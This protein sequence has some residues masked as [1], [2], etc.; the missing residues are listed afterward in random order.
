MQLLKFQLSFSY[1]LILQQ[2][3]PYLELLQF[4]IYHVILWKCKA[5]I[6]WI[7]FICENQE[8]PEHSG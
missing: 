2:T 5:V 1:N 8:P 7:L 4:N 6:I 3:K